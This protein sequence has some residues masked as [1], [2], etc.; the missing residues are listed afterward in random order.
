MRMRRLHTLC[1]YV[2]L[3]PTPTVA[4]TYDRGSNNITTP[5]LEI[6]THY[7]PV[8][9]LDLQ[10]MQS[11]YIPPNRLNANNPI[12]HN[13]IPPAVSPTKPTLAEVMCERGYKISQQWCGETNSCALA[14]TPQA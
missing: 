13:S 10:V 5:L 8:Y 9:R 2:A 3:R 14:C 11:L 6:A 12:P 4:I 1:S 7:N